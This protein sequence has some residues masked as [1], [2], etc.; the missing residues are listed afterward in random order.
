MSINTAAAIIIIVFLGAAVIAI[1]TTFKKLSGRQCGEN[2]NSLKKEK[3]G[4]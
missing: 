4:L 2:G 1:K 3:E